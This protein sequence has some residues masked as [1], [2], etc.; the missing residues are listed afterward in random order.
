MNDNDLTKTF[1]SSDGDGENKLEISPNS[2]DGTPGEVYIA[3]SFQ[4]YTYHKEVS[5]SISLSPEDAFKALRAIADAAGLEVRTTASGIH[6]KEPTPSAVQNR[7]DEL[8]QRFLYGN[9]AEASHHE[10]QL[11]D[12]IIEGELERGELTK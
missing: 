6:I 11:I 5:E 2:G 9:Y 4:E 3:I 8:A 10:Q 1:K 12:F 7:R